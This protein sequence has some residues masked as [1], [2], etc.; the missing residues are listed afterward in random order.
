MIGRSGW[1]QTATTSGAKPASW[2]SF[3]LAARRSSGGHRSPEDMP[4]LSSPSRQNVF[5]R[6]RRHG[7]QYQGGEAQAGSSPREPSHSGPSTPSLASKSQRTR[8]PSPTRSATRP[9]RAARRLSAAARCT[10]WGRKGICSAATRAG[11]AI[12]WQ[13]GAGRKN[14]TPIQPLWGFS[15]HP[16]IEGHNASSRW[17]AGKAAT[18]SP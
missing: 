3:R 8:S 17:P 4:C 11:G 2:K 12:V 18:L 15:A 1:D 5:E 14:T 9:G 7:R 10:F 13:K 16:L 6:L